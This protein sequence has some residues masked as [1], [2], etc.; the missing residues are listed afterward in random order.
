MKTQP[1]NE[2]LIDYAHGT[3]SDKVADLLNR[4]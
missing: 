4:L 3:A 1:T 2:D